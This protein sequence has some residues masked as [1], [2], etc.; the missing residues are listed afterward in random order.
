MSAG[1]SLEIILLLQ[2]HRQ[3][4]DGTLNYILP[5]EEKYFKMEFAV[6]KNNEDINDFKV[7]C[8]KW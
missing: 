4:R 6:L 5:D 2:E 1:W 8:L 7:K 3:E